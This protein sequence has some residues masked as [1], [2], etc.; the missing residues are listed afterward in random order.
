[1]N[2]YDKVRIIK[3]IDSRFDVVNIETGEYLRFGFEAEN[4]VK[5]WVEGLDIKTLKPI[6]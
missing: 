6:M 1:M 2:I 3:N 5:S 4:E